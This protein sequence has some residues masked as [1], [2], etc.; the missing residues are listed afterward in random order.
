M[1]RADRD[2][3]R[4]FLCPA[5]RQER[6]AR[7]RHSPGTEPLS[8]PAPDRGART[9]FGPG[10]HHRGYPAGRATPTA[11][12]AAPGPGP[13]RFPKPEPAGPGGGHPSRPNRRSARQRRESRPRRA[14]PI[15]GGPRE[16][17]P[18]PATATHPDVSR[19]PSGSRSAPSPDSSAPAPVPP[20]PR[21]AAPGS[22]GQ[23]PERRSTPQAP[24]QTHL[25]AL[26]QGDPLAG[27][28]YR[29]E[30]ATHASTSHGVPGED[31]PWRPSATAPAQPPQANPRNPQAARSGPATKRP[32]PVRL[33]PR[34]SASWEPRY[35]QDRQV[36]A[37]RY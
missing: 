30:W 2:P 37:T 36:H 24:P 31:P 23:A 3:P 19:S 11:G 20:P 4:T 5:R 27:Q 6:S 12:E 33:T 8:R 32:G 16:V 10:G 26:R 14:S 25:R 34:I 13:A 22:I 15:P 7:T 17:R 28:P 21:H 9:R 1:R 35:R 18:R 29:A